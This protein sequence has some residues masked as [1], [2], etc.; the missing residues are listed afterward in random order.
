[1]PSKPGKAQRALTDR[2]CAQVLAAGAGKT[3][4]EV[5]AVAT[6][7]P[8]QGPSAQTVRSWAVEHGY[9][10]QPT[11]RIPHAV[12]AAYSEATRVSCIRNLAT[13]PNR[14]GRT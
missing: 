2:R 3:G 8:P 4:S 6:S 10:V 13:Q 12:A 1:M 14:K 9:R 7:Q 5:Q 11:G